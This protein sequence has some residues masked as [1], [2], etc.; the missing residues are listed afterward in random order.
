MN[1]S[2]PPGSSRDEELRQKNLRLLRRLI[3][4]AIGLVLFSVGYI[5]YYSKYL[6]DSGP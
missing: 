4:L 6:K 2:P 3:A 5:I 1:A